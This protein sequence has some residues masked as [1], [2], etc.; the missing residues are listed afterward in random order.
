MSAC[1]KAPSLSHGPSLPACQLHPPWLQRVSS[2]AS[3][4]VN[5]TSGHA[6]IAQMTSV[7]KSKPIVITLIFFPST[8]PPSK[9]RKEK[10]IPSKPRQRHIQWHRELA[11][12]NDVSNIDRQATDGMIHF[13]YLFVFVCTGIE[14]AIRGYPCALVQ[15]IK[16]SN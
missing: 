7:Q 3:Y 2:R 6:S 11:G 8:N 13:L 1:V 9:A 16:L 5:K 12:G 4:P 14:C 10:V 15:Q